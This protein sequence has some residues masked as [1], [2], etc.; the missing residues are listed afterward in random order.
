MFCALKIG[1]KVGILLPRLR[2]SLGRRTQIA[3]VRVF[4]R[5]Y[6]RIIA[7]LR[8]GLLNSEYF[9]SEVRVLYELATRQEST[10]REIAA[11][12]KLDAGYLSRMLRKLE[13]AGL[14]SRKASG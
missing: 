5:L 3:A 12:L 9:L 1:R 14:L 6:T 7:T 4:N 2:A 13:C 10:A 11:D 8:E